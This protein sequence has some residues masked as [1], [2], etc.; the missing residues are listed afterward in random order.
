MIATSSIQKSA[1]KRIT[2]KQVKASVIPSFWPLILKRWSKVKN[3]ENHAHFTWP[4]PLNVV[5]PGS[6]SLNVNQ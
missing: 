3:Q 2:R 5:V 4:P 1:I 6:F